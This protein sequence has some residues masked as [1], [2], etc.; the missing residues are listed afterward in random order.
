MFMCNFRQQGGNLW[1]HQQVDG[2]IY[3]PLKI[4]EFTTPL[5]VPKRPSPGLHN[6]MPVVVSCVRCFAVFTGNQ[7]QGIKYYFSELF[8][9]TEFVLLFYFTVHALPIISRASISYTS[10]INNV[11][12]RQPFVISNMVQF[13]RSILQTKVR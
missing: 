3:L 4:F 1:V 6:I 12:S 2:K 9:L 8:F 7:I 11:S 5:L 10:V 13:M